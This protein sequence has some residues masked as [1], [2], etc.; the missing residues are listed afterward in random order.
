MRI[1]FVSGVAVGGSARSTRELADHLAQRGHDVATLL[2]VER[3][4]RRRYLHTRAVNLTVKLGASPLT[5]PVAGAAATIG[6]RPVRT[7]GPSNVESWET[8]LPQNSLS[9]V[10]GSFHPDVVVTSSIDRMAWRRIRRL[11]QKRGIPS[12]LY[13]REH[14]AFGHLTVSAAPP[15]LLIANARAHEDTAR[16][17]GHHAITIPSLVSV[18]H[19]LVE[20]RRER[21]LL[22]NPTPLYGLDIAL[23]VV[24][25]RPGVLFTFA[26]STPL[27]PA[28]RDALL[29]E[30]GRCPNVELREFDPDARRLYADASVLLAPYRS[31]GRPRVVLEA[32]ANGIPVLGSDLPAVQEAI[33]PGGIVLAAD[34]PVDAWAAAL[35]RMLEPATYGRLA[36]AARR[37]A[38]RPEVDPDAIAERFERALADL[39]ATS[40]G[41]TA[42][43][44]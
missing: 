18:R 21:V 33:G 27:E 5:R 34:L 40:S 31:N 26:P 20:S 2:Q 15:D 7:P 23:G 19:C 30:I 4:R 6:R 29:A 36:D 17:L 43:E 12:V 16:R 14:N 39:V 11:L 37:H 44:R 3:A 32:Q 8:F 35:D 22:V 13:V 10:I 24:R 38:R 1:L 9:A 28:A 41:L 42:T 25:A